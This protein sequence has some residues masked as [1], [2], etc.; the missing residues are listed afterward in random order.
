[1]TK[2]LQRGEYDP[3]LKRVKEQ[4]ASSSNSQKGEKV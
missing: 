1:M 4:F 3:I 2:A